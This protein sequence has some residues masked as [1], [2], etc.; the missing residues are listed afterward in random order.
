MVPAA[1]GGAPCLWDGVT[2]ARSDIQVLLHGTPGAALPVAKRAV[3]SS[4]QDRDVP[5]LTC[6][7]YSSCERYFVFKK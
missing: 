2:G 1:T 7:L 6:P 4:L 3:G 5:V